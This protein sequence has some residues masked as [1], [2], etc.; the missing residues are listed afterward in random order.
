MH[1]IERLENRQLFAADPMF[2]LTSKGTLIVEGSGGDDQ[3][4]ATLVGGH[5]KVGLLY[6]MISSNLGGK[7]EYFTVFHETKVSYPKVKRIVIDG[8]DGNDTID[9]NSNQITKPVTLL[10]GN[11][12]DKITFDTGGGVY[13]D[14]GAGD[15]TIGNRAPTLIALGAKTKNHDVLSD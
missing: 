4:S 2:T 1:N 6:V 11:G 10:G 8:G 14:G 7:N 12:D 9:I 13:A 15:D 5:T 3:I